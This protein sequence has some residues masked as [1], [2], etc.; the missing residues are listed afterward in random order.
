VRVLVQV[1]PPRADEREV[2]EVAVPAGVKEC[3]RRDGNGEVEGTGEVVLHA[4][5]TG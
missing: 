5:A 3:Y 2:F 4:A 1:I